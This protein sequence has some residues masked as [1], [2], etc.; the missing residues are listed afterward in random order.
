VHEL[1]AAQERG[2]LFHAD[3]AHSVWV[4]ET[5]VVQPEVVWQTSGPI[6]AGRRSILPTHGSDLLASWMNSAKLMNLMNF[7]GTGVEPL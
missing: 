2:G 4:G 3:R 5:G 1:D 7:W 6:P